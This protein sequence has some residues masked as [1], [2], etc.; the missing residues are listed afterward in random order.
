M[1]IIFEI[2]RSRRKRETEERKGRNIERGIDLESMASVKPR[3]WFAGSKSR[4]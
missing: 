4:I 3:K 2:E 1:R